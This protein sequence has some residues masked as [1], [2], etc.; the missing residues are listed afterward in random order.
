[1]RAIADHVMLVDFV[2]NAKQIEFLANRSNR[3]QFSKGEHL[4]G[5]IDGCAD[6]DRAQ[7]MRR[8]V[9]QFTTASSEF[10]AI[11]LEAVAVQLQYLCA[12]AEFIG[13]APVIWIVGFKD[14]RG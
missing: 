2:G 10:L 8:A 11:Q 13:N 5:R 4:A 12:S 14:E 3:F 9:L 6:N 7:R 1:M